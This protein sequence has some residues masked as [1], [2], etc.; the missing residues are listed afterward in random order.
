[1]TGSLA[2]VRTRAFTLIEL[3]AV[4]VVLAILSAVAIPRYFDYADQAKTAALQGSLGAVRAG[5][6]NFF[7]DQAIQGNAQYPNAT[8]LTTVGT[9]MQEALPQNP[10]NSLNTVKVISSLGTATARTADGTTG[11]AYFVDNA[12]NPP[13]AIFYANSDDDTT[14]TSGGSAVTANDL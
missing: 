6:A 3:V 1:M 9:V 8:E 13:V 14:E 5:I 4:I 7:A 2:S 12:A 11:W 10:F